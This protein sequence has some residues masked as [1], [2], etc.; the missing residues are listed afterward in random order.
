MPKTPSQRLR[1]PTLAAAGILIACCAAGCGATSK[2]LAG[3]IPPGAQTAGHAKVDDPRIKHLR[4]LRAHH[5][6][7]RSVGQTEIDIGNAANGPIVRFQPTPGDA[8]ALQIKGQ[9]EG[10][11]VIGSA[12]LFPRGASDA[13]LKV[14]EDCVAQGVKG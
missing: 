10:A 13:R 6:T 14:I 4:C 12:L 8:Q 2:P 11:E 1:T 7:A 3:T 9:V 5:V